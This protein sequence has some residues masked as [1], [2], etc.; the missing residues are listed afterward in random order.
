MIKTLKNIPVW[1]LANFFLVICILRITDFIHI[2]LYLLN[3]FILSCVLWGGI[4][5]IWKRKTAFDIF[6]IL[7]LSYITLNMLFSDYPHS[8][9]LKYRALLA[10]YAYVFFYFIGRY[11]NRITTNTI[12]RK[13][14]WPLIFCMVCGIYFY[15]TLPA[16]Y[17]GMKEAQLSNR[18]SDTVF[19]EVYRL[20][21]FWGHPYTLGYAVLLY[22]IFLMNK[23]FGVEKY[24]EKVLDI[25]LL[26]FCAVILLLAQLRVTII[27]YLLF[28]MYFFVKNNKLSW[29]YSIFTTLILFSF[30]TFFPLILQEMDM[31]AVSYIIEHMDKLTQEGVLSSRLEFTSGGVELNSLFGDGFGRYDLPARKY[32]MFSLC[33]SEYQNHLAELGYIGFLQL[34]ILLLFSFTRAFNLRRY[35]SVELCILVFY[36][37]NMIGASSL[38]NTHQYGYIFWFCL[39]QIWNNENIYRKQNISYQLQ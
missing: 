25:C 19:Y 11:T 34:V 37:I 15:F 4:L 35:L 18:V 6:V 21:S 27:C 24:K 33:D 22:T 17:V 8:G 38:S 9:E 29:K 28:L 39:G 23:L 12:L 20:S 14:K 3:L 5:F 31:G 16:W 36:V 2:E 26:L 1:L 30:I 10:Q 32:N 13:M 7:Y